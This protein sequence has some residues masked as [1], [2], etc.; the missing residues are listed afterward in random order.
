MKR[1]YRNQ[2]YIRHRIDKTRYPHRDKIITITEG[3]TGRI[4]ETKTA[5]YKTERH[6]IPNEENG[7]WETLFRYG[8]FS[9]RR[10]KTSGRCFFFYDDR[11][12]EEISELEILRFG[13]RMIGSVNGFR[14]E[15]FT[16]RNGKPYRRYVLKAESYWKNEH[17]F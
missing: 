12:L 3:P 7:N 2:K 14:E 15:I 8:R 11:Y 10:S 4:V 17:G 13:N 1:I 6:R 16:M 9:I 5:E